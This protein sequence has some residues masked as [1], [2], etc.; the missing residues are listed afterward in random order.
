M[1]HSKKDDDEHQLLMAQRLIEFEKL[2]K[3]QPQLPHNI[4]STLLRRFV[5][6]TR[7][8]LAAAQRLLE[9]NYAQR[10]KHA[11]I[12][13]DR[14]PMDASSQQLLQVADLVPLPGLTPENNKLLF[15]RLIDY[16]ADKFNFTASIKVFFMVADCRFATETEGRLSD[17]EIPI[18]D[19]AGY[20]LRHLTKTALSALRV[21][22][23]FVQEAHPV[24]LKEIHVINCPSYLDKVLTVVKPFI[25]SEV[26][27]LIHFHLPNA[28]TPYDHFPRAMMPE[29]YGGNAGKM[30]D[31]K[32]HWMQLLQQHREYLMDAG[33]WRLNKCN[34][35][36]KP[37][38]SLKTLEID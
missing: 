4:S 5:H 20:T 11:H 8:D 13:I 26:F 19:M 2:I 1:V 37:T 27:K 3:A 12:F 21:Y 18:F 6:T 36:K 9:L 22:M 33:N 16:D 14:D 30:S 38:Q 23:K 29:E 24:R 31:L 17:G 10:N 35:K 7:G 32:Q 34:D 28:D 15:Y 25:K